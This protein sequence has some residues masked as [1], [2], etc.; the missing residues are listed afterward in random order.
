MKLMRYSLIILFSIPL[1]MAQ[2]FPDNISDDMKKQFFELTQEQKELIAA[3]YGI[4]LNDLNEAK[5]SQSSLQ[6]DDRFL[7][8]QQLSEGQQQYIP[9]IY[10]NPSYMNFQRD[11][12]LKQN[13]LSAQSD[14]FDQNGNPIITEPQVNQKFNKTDKNK[15]YDIFGNLLDPDD[16]DDTEDEKLTRFGLSF[17]D[18]KISTFSPFENVPVPDDYRLGAGD[19]IFIKLVGAENSQLNLTIDRNGTIFVPKIGEITV[20]GINFKEAINIIQSRI[21][22]E[23]IGVSAFITMGRIKS[24]NIFMAGEVGSQVCIP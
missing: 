5:S 20:S 11:Q 19:E 22:K 12:F 8:D 16:A 6:P 17:F 24:I 14:C 4:D 2:T 10:S 21:E 18:T 23:L 9:K 3:E 1:L 13:P 7:N 15:C